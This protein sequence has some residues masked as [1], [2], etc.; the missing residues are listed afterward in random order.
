MYKILIVEDDREIRQILEFYLSRSGRYNITFAHSAE[1]AIVAADAVHFDVMLLDI[2]LPGMDGISL[3]ERLRKNSFCPIIFISC[4]DDDE[5]IVRAFR[6]GGDDYLVKPFRGPV[7]L[8]HIEAVLRRSSTPPVGG[9]LLHADSLTLDTDTHSVTLEGRPVALSPTEY[10]ILCYF[11]RNPGRFISFEELYENIWQ[12]P[13]LGDVRTLFV[14]IRNLR[15][16]IEPDAAN[17][18]YIRTQLRDGYIFG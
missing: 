12:R 15:K 13:S 9:D 6:M 7:L 16:K 14:H 10:Q 18:S 2:M 1:E 5:T 8:A 17:P 4:L 11:M 3:C